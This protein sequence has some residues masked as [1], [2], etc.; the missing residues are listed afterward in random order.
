MAIGITGIDIHIP[1]WRMDG[2]HWK[3]GLGTG[4]KF[5]R[6]VASFD[7]DALTMAHE[8]ARPLS[9]GVDAL[10][11]ASTSAPYREKSSAATLAAALN[12]PNSVRIAEYAGSLRAATQAINAALD[13]IKAG[14]I[15]SALIASGELRLSAPGSAP[16]SQLGDAGAAVRLSH[17]APVEIV[18]THSVTEEFLDRWRREE[19]RFIW[20]G[21]TKFGLEMGWLASMPRALDALLAKAGIEKSA[22]AAVAF[23]APD[24]KSRKAL[25]KSMKLADTQWA[26][27]SVMDTVGD[28]GTVNIL[29]ELAL[30]LSKAKAGD[31]VALVNWS[32]G[33]DAMLLKVHR[34]LAVDVA[35]RL[36]P[37]NGRALPSYGHYLKFRNLIEQEPL[38][39]F[40]SPTVLHR[41]EKATLRLMASKCAACGTVQYPPRRICLSCHA[42][43][44]ME[45][46]RLQTAG[47]VFTLTR[48]HLYPTPLSPVTMVS[49]DLDGGCR[50]YAQMADLD[51]VA[52]S[53]AI[54]D[55]VRLVLRRIHEG[56][57]YHNYFW[58]FVRA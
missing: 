50:F 20:A 10:F 46:T 25:A 5:T 47:T 32:D 42:K 44:K 28:A 37:S 4:G 26:S 6:A 30:V 1:R 13:S 7:E 31:T 53:M 58:K 33:C 22:L 17:D 36:D 9:E 43:D 54:G 35:Q 18:A 57:H 34:P 55:R 23:N 12:L 16:E 41:E 15:R 14:S 21:D 24:S 45:D 39:P 38:A 49:A 29:L 27:P 8:A 48:D 52:E 56:E 51:P 2:S 11:F 3:S 19:D 40:T